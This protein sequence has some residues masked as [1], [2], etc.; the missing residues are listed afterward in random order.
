MDD[1][2]G[3]SDAVGVV[4]ARLRS[5]ADGAVIVETVTATLSAAELPDTPMRRRLVVE[6]ESRTLSVRPGRR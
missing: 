6:Y 4:R 3:I 1:Q 2:V 5:V